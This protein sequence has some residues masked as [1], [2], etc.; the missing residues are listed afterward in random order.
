M[1]WF[2]VLIGSIA[3]E[4]LFDPPKALAGVVS[5]QPL[6]IEKRALEFPTARRNTD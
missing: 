3:A 5:N 4:D 6:L 1:R 2:L